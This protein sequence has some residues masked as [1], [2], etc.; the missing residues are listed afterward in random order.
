MP[1]CRPAARTASKAAETTATFCPWSP[2]QRFPTSTSS[3]MPVGRTPAAAARASASRTVAA[4]KLAGATPA[5]GALRLMYAA[6]R[7]RVSAHVHSWLRQRLT[8]RGRPPVMPTIANEP[9]A[10][11]SCGPCG[12]HC[13]Q[14]MS[15][16]N[17]CHRSPVT[18]LCRAAGAAGWVEDPAGTADRDG[19]TDGAGTCRGETGAPAAADTSC[20]WTG[21]TCASPT[22]STAVNTAA[23][24]AWACARWP[25]RPGEL[26]GSLSLPRVI[27]P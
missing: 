3:Q 18:A 10:G 6:R 25:E 16:P 22:A 23:I 21:H 1:G 2:L 4:P 26:A 20:G 13:G 24:T 12:A 15:N 17:Q 19:D 9:T 27:Y 7:G 11:G 8:V 5:G 14:E